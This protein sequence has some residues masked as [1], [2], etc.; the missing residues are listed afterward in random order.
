MNVEPVIVDS[1]R[2]LSGSKPV[3]R[4]GVILRGA[5]VSEDMAGWVHGEKKMYRG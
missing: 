5:G 3:R 4:A 1:E 2:I